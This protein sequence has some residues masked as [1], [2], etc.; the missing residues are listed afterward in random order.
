MK[1]Q[2]VKGA[3][4]AFNMELE[5]NKRET[6]KRITLQAKFSPNDEGETIL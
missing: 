1:L 2:E 5:E 3:L 4:K 6:K